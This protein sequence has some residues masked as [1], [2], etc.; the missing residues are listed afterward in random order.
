MHSRSKPSFNPETFKYESKII[1][2]NA[3]LNNAYIL[4]NIK[5]INKP[6]TPPPYDQTE[7]IDLHLL[8]NFFK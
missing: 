2:I 4:Y 6:N 1:K 7:T 8:L 5:A 3:C